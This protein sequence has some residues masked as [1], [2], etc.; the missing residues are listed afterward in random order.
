MI[1]IQVNFNLSVP[2]FGVPS[3]FY[4]FFNNFAKDTSFSYPLIQVLAVEK[5]C[6]HTKYGLDSYEQNLSRHHSTN[7][8]TLIDV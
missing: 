2:I 7:I 8:E 1:S 6:F 5:N 4:G 3:M